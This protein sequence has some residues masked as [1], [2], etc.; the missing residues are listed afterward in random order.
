L[1]AAGAQLRDSSSAAESFSAE[2]TTLVSGTERSL[3]LVQSSRI[4][5]TSE[6]SVAFSPAT[7][8]G[9]GACS[10]ALVA[11]SGFVSSSGSR[12][13]AAAA[14]PPRLPE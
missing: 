5:S 3:R 4:D 14:A 9:R 13:L 12:R 6:R 11:G 10:S 1:L 2:S 7:T 8:I